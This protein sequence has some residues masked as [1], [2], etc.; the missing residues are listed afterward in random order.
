MTLIELAWCLSG[1][2]A[3]H[4][5]EATPPPPTADEFDEMAS[6][7]LALVSQLSPSCDG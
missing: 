4:G 7:H 1:Y 5:G 2:N 6:E 3:A